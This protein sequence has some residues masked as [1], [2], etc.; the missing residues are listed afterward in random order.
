MLHDP[1]QVAGCAAVVKAGLVVHHTA[2]RTKVPGQ[3]I[4]TVV[5]QRPR[6]SLHVRTLAV[7]F[8]AMG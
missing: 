3:Y 5:Q 8:Q 7:P 2:A 4:P 1:V 6:Q